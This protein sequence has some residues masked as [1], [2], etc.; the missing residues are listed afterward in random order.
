MRQRER[1]GK[2]EGAKQ[3]IASMNIPTETYSLQ[4]GPVSYVSITSQ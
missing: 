2:E 3:D 1:G 4:L